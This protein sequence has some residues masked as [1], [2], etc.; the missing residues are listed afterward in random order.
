MSGHFGFFFQVRATT[1]HVFK[2]FRHILSLSILGIQFFLRAFYL[3]PHSNCSRTSHGVV[4][5]FSSQ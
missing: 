5:L 1:M 3:F 4:Y 2:E